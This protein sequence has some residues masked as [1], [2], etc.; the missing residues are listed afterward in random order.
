LSI[1]KYIEVYAR[2][3]ISFDV[4]SGESQVTQESQDE[5]LRKLEGSGIMKRDNGALLVDLSEYNLQKTLVEKRDGTKLYITRD[6][7]GAAERYEK[8]KFD[9]MM[10]V[11][12]RYCYLFFLAGLTCY[13]TATW[14]QVSKTY[15]L[16]R[17]SRS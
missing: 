4:Y 13:E 17:C 10:C 16:S 8:Y 12:L 6:L 3:N 15:T 2:L 7:G 9:K 1:K 11:C 14:S 5:A